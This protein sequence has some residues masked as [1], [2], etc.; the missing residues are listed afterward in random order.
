MPNTNEHSGSEPRREIGSRRISELAGVPMSGLSQ[1]RK[2]W[3]GCPM[4]DDPPKTGTV[5][6]FRNPAWTLA[7]WEL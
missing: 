7:E 3:P 5:S 6:G 2:R 1:T 4:S